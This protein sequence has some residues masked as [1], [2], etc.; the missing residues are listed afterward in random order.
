MNKIT[1]DNEDIICWKNYNIQK[2]YIGKGSF[3]KVYKAFNTKNN[4]FY[5]IKKMNFS[6]FSSTLK[7]RIHNELFI[8]QNISNENI[9]QFVDFEYEDKFL[10]IIFEL[11]DS[12]ISTWIGNIHNEDILKNNFLQIVKGI[13]YIH[14]KNI[15]HRDIKPEN[16]LLK[17]NIPKI[18][19]F[20]FSAI[21]KDEL[22][23][24][25]TICGTPLYMSPETLFFKPYSKKSDIW[26]LGILFY[27]IAYGKHPY[28]V[29]NSIEE[30]KNKIKFEII[31]F[32]DRNYS[33]LFVD[34]ISNMLKIKESDRYSIQDVYNHP[35]FKYKDEFDFTDIFENNDDESINETINE[36]IN[37]NNDNNESI[38][39]NLNE[40]NEN[41]NENLNETNDNERNY[42]INQN[43]DYE[44]YKKYK[45]IKIDGNLSET[46]YKSSYEIYGK[47]DFHDNY[48]NSKKITMN[49]INLIDKYYDDFSSNTTRISDKQNQSFSSSCPPIPIK[50][51]KKDI[52]HS[53]SL[54]NILYSSFEYII[55]KLSI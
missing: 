5:A 40:T 1:S 34:L 6:E 12:D 22:T 37:E 19:D 46:T 30:Y 28:G 27:F 13:D 24:N 47:K 21:I 48:K 44:K 49:H 45:N 42:H 9:I 33:D 41:L 20:G 51:I 11:C 35:W 31:K 18:C 3:S 23:M 7:K 15:L 52:Q 50:N 36:S 25:N 17:N 14:S 16:I 8:L 4:Q 55:E 32:K 2:K 29:V 54:K 53:S 10:F 39:E 26:S 43:E 38:N